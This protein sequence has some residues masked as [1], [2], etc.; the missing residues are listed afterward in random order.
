MEL[1][2]PVELYDLNGFYM[3]IT[4]ACNLRCLHC[5]NDSGVLKNQINFVDFEKIVNEFDDP[6]TS[7]TL[8]G[9]EPLMHPDFKCFLDCLAAKKFK[10][11]LIVTN[12]TL[13]NEEIAGYIAKSKVPVQVSINGMSSKEHDLLCGVGNFERTMSGLEKTCVMQVIIGL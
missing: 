11:S 1:L 5:Y 10:N 8:S 2:E 6:E 7:I 3:E 9:G 13:I 12:A 4:S